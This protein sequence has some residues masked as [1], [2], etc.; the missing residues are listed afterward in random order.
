MSKIGLVTIHAANSYGGVLQA[1]ASQSVLQNYG[2]VEFINYRTRHIKNTMKLLR[3]GDGARGVLRGGKDVF[4][5]W[6]RKKLLE[7]FNNF[8]EKNMIIGEEVSSVGDC[9][10]RFKNFD[11][12]V[13]GSDQIWNPNI[14]GGLDPIYFHA[15]PTRAKKI[16]FSTSYGSYIFDEKERLALR[17]YLKDFH[18]IAMRE[19]DSSIFIGDIV[20]FA[21]DNTLDPTL[22]LDADQ[23]SKVIPDDSICIDKNYVLIYALKKNK[24]MIKIIDY[25]TKELK[26]HVV[27]IDQDPFCGYRVDEKISFGGP[28]DYLNLFANANFVIT[29]SFHGTVFSLNFN[30]NFIAINPES[31]KNRI[32]GVLDL[33]GLSDRFVENVEDIENGML[34]E[35]INFS[36]C[37]M[38]LKNLKMKS[39][40]YLDRA[41]SC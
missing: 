25:I 37:N 16:A 36:E 17:G 35:D 11:F 7:R 41:F 33:V 22:L 20:N 29:N 8:L 26:M 14:M 28:G 24:E 38:R 13:C 6:S 27:A 4:R 34:F 2:N 23:W 19:N 40:N 10:K 15:Y 12:L 30:K 39:M 32:T 5:F 1:Y 9:E 3:F 18:A 21:V 31:G